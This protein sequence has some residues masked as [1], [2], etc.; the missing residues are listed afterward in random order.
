MIVGEAPGRE[1]DAQGEPFIGRSGQLLKQLLDQA[2]IRDYYVTNVV[3]C[4]PNRTPSTTEIAACRRYLEEEILVQQPSYILAL[5]NSAWHRFGRGPITEHAGKEIWSE[6]HQCFVMPA[7]HPA[8]ILRD[9]QKERAWSADIHR[10]ARLVRGE[11]V[12][13][14]DV[15]VHL[16]QSESDL[17]DLVSILQNSQGFTYDFETHPVPWWRKDWY[18][19][20]VAFSL[21]GREAYV[22]PF[23]VEG[24]PMGVDLAWESA[25]EAWTRTMRG[26]LTD[27]TLP[28]TAH[29]M[30]FDD[31]C[32]FR[33]TGT[34]PFTTFDTMVAAQLLDENRPKSLKWLGRAILGWPEWDIDARKPHPLDKLAGY[35]GMDAAATALLRE[36]FLHELQAQPRLWEYFRRLEMPKLRALTQVMANGVWVDEHTL[37]NAQAVTELELHA[38]K[39]ALPGIQNPASTRQLGKWLYEDLKLPCP[40]LTKSGAQSCDEETIK[41]LA[42]YHPAVR[43]VLAF[44][45]QNRYRSGY[46]TPISKQLATSFDGRLHPEYRSTS[47]ETGR[48]ASPFHTTPRDSRIRTVYAAPPGYTLL[49]PDFAQVEARLAA[50]AAAGRPGTWA[51]AQTTQGVGTL[52]LQACTMLDAWMAGLDVYCETAA[53]ILQKPADQVTRDKSDPNSERQIVGKVPTLALLYNMT[54]KGLREYVWKEFELDWTAKFSAQVYQG[55]YAR[56]AEFASW[57]KREAATLSARGYAI[58]A[59]GRLR[60]LPAALEG[61]PFQTQ[62]DALN[63]GINAPIQSLASDITQACMIALDQLGFKIVGNVHDQLLIEVPDDELTKAAITV[64]YV[65]RNV[66]TMLRPLGLELPDGLLEVEML[67][68]PWGDAKLVPSA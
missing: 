47:A 52:P 35:N 17:K 7:L 44:R 37:K 27:P 18:A 43:G 21:T 42:R 54:A 41:H 2:G 45:K 14:P 5:G 11:L 29:N 1:E 68:G 60:R 64:G 30:L 36:R 24:A 63:A 19:K 9:P 26:V 25:L 57:H 22:V 49:Q 51:G 33:M 32:W 16:A 67:A 13:R 65:M 55:F 53:A 58:S 46:L 40:K 12:N 6:K 28:K 48:L 4:F 62:R 10:F 23:Y 66:H 8:A 15:K 34:L 59:L 31:L 61:S 38:A 39:Q 50:W 3:K 20:T 56:W